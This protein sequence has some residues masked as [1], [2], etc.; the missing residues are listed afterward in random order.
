MFAGALVLWLVIQK[1]AWP[2]IAKHHK[3]NI[4]T[5]KNLTELLGII[6]RGLY[7]TS[8]IMG[9]PAWI[10][11]WLALKVAA[12]WQ[13]WQGEERVTYNVFLIGNGLSVAFGVIGAWIALGKF[14]KFSI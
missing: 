11:A 9:V 2:Y 10:P 8:I 6:E 3:I 1:L 7:T 12:R 5:S 13:R 14:P 4:G